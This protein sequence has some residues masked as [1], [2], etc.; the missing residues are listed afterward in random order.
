MKT[1]K[2]NN[3]ESATTDLGFIRAINENTSGGGEIRLANAELGDKFTKITFKPEI[4]LPYSLGEEDVYNPE[5]IDENGNGLGSL[6]SFDILGLEINVTTSSGKKYITYT[7]DDGITYT[8]EDTE[9]ILD[10]GKTVECKPGEEYWHELLGYFFQ[11][12]KEAL[13]S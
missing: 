7:S 2:Q 6:N 9:L 12:E 13:S 4:V 3:L 11:I 1:L 8:T 5:F 10:F